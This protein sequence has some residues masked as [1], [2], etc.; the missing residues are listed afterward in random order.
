MIRIAAVALLR[1]MYWVASR[2]RISHHI[3]AVCL[4]GRRA[5]VTSQWMVT[6]RGM[7][8]IAST[9]RS[10]V[11]SWLRRKWVSLRGSAKLLER[12]L[13]ILSQRPRSSTARIGRGISTRPRKCT[14]GIAWPRCPATELPR[15]LSSRVTSAIAR[16]VLQGLHAGWRSRRV[17]VNARNGRPSRSRFFSCRMSTSGSSSWRRT[18]FACSVPRTSARA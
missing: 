15:W 17:P 16:V 9:W 8:E 10:S 6:S 5:L 3:M 12:R 18:T 14:W 13:S 7:P 11:M 2:L 1:C 4:G